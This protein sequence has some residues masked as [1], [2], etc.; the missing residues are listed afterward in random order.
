MMRKT[1]KL[2][3]ANWKMNP[4]SLREA[5]VLY[6]AIRKTGMRLHNVETVVCPPYVFLESLS[7]KSGGHRVM[8]GAQDV[9]FKKGG[10][11]TGEISSTMLFEVGVRYVIIGHSERRAIGETDEDVSKKIK[12]ALKDGL[13]VVLAIGESVR[14]EEGTYLSVVASQIRASLSGVPRSLVSN[15]V[16]AYEPIWAVGAASGDSEDTP[17]ALVEMVIFIRKIL[18]ELYGKPLAMS[19]PILYGGSVTPKNAKAF[20]QEGGVSGLLVGRASNDPKKFNE[21]LEIANE[22]ENR[23]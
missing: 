9:S 10:P 7:K 14:D 23:E 21:I 15:L 19:T 16:V 17:A 11:Y 8:L 6:A 20:L 18:D 1:K 5:H 4:K 22:I 3:V 13:R 2:I 12:V